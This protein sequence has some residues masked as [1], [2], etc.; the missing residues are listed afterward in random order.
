MKTAA[1]LLRMVQQKEERVQI[2]HAIIDGCFRLYTSR[3]FLMCSSQVSFFCCVQLNSS[4]LTHNVAQSS[5]KIEHVVL[6]QVVKGNG[7]L[8][9]A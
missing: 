9:D 3:S 5:E 8:K 1:C 7:I 4:E 6:L 2:P